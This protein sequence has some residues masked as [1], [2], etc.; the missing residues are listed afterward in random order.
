MQRNHVDTHEGWPGHTALAK[1]SAEH[2]PQQLPARNCLSHFGRAPLKTHCG[3]GT[4]ATG[5]HSWFC[6]WEVAQLLKISATPEY[7]DSKTAEGTLQS[8]QVWASQEQP[9]VRP[10][11]KHTQM[12]P[13]V[14]T[15]QG[16][17]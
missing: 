2:L 7:M 13:D 14:P 8:L 1:P 11:S 9:V 15:V 6:F 4:K 17:R 5:G 16:R 12:S 10:H 3:N